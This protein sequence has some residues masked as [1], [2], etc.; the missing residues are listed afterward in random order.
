L[1]LIIA[2]YVLPLFQNVDCFTFSR[3]VDFVLYVFWHNI[4]FRLRRVEKFMYLEKKMIK[5]STFWNGASEEVYGKYV[6]CWW[7]VIVFIRLI[8]LQARSS[9]NKR[10]W[11]WKVKRAMGS[12]CMHPWEARASSS[13]VLCSHMSQFASIVLVLNQI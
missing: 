12:I 7:M 5:R 6:Y 2:Y 3:Y 1:L 9:T 4:I 13:H 10:K 8:N 11:R